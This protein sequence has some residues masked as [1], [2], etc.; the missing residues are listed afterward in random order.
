MM[1]YIGT[2]KGSIREKEKGGG[3]G[4]GRGVFCAVWHLALKAKGIT[5]P[6]IFFPI[7]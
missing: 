3:G 1:N 6:E 5:L 2:V 4:G 7:H